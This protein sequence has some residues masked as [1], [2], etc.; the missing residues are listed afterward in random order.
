MDV[1]H[2][3]ADLASAPFIVQ[4]LGDSFGLMQSVQHLPDFAEKVEDRPQLQA[5]LERLL[6]I[7]AA[8][9]ECLENAQPLLEGIGSLAGLPIAR[10]RV[11]RPYANSR[12]P[13]S[14][15]LPQ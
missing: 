9:R 6:Q 2:E 4:P 10:W 5:D 3:C 7:N 8:F 12:S 13:H 15:V 14:Q 11:D 1:G